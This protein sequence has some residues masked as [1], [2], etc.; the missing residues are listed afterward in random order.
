VTKSFILEQVQCSDVARRRLRSHDVS[1]PCWFCAGTTDALVRTD[2]AVRTEV[3]SRCIFYT[4][5][6]SSA[7]AHQNGSS[8]ALERDLFGRV[9]WRVSSRMISRRST[10]AQELPKI[11]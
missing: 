1:G 7:D 6:F 2:G 3:K 9:L 4:Y 10:Q 11:A 8:V 5:L